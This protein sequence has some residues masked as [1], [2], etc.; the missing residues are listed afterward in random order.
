MSKGSMAIDFPDG[1][2]R[3]QQERYRDSLA[4][5]R[6]RYMDDRNEETRAAFRTALKVFADLVLRNKIPEDLG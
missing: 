6:D 4:D 3:Q 5:A 1:V 2:T